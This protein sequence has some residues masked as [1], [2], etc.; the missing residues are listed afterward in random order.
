MNVLP[1]NYIYIKAMMG[2]GSDNI[3]GL[4][5]IG[6]KTALKLFPFLSER[7]ST[8][9]E[10]RNHSVA[11]IDN[12]PKYKSILDQWD[13]F[14]E[15]VQLMQLSNP[16]ISAQSARTVRIS[17]TEQKPRFVFTEFKLELIKHGIQVIDADMMQV[18]QAYKFRVEA[19]R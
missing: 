1:E 16:I 17:A 3:K 15:N 11:N 2:D 5:G 18:L 6:E 9:E 12:G 13:H 19:S 10:I 4:G 7:E 8:V 14:L